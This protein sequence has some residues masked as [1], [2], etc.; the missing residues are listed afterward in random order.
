MGSPEIPLGP[1]VTLVDLDKWFQP[2]IV[3]AQVRDGELERVR[4][5]LNGGCYLK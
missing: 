2:A 4:E 5:F 1:G 3:P